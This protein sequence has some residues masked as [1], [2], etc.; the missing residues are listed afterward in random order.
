MGRWLAQDALPVFLQD[1][2][3]EPGGTEVALH[4]YDARAAVQVNNELNFISD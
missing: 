3:D 4:R 1:E 2:E